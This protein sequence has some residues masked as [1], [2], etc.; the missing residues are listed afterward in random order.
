MTPR[1]EYAVVVAVLAAGGAAGLLASGAVWQE[2][3]GD[4]PLP[5]LPE[6][7][8]GTEAAPAVR[9]VSLVALA[10]TLAVL[11]TRRRG[12]RAVGVLLALAGLVAAAAAVSWVGGD[13]TRWPA[14]ALGA[15]LTVTAAG[16]LVA[17]RG[18]RWPVLGA[19]YERGSRPVE[20]SRSTWDALDRGEDP[21]V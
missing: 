9:A 12:R 3:P 20:T 16:V 11:A 2:V 10:G 18:G 13:S 4:L 17:V 8:T 6:V 5:V 21:T 14:V 1:R 19:R 15:A 7:V